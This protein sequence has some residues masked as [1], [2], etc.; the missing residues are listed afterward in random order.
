MYP[1]QE[2]YP[3][4]QPSGAE[5][6]PPQGP[7]G[8]PSEGVPYPYGQQGPYTPPPGAGPYS[9]GQ[10]GPYAP[11][12]PEA[13]PYSY[14]AQGPYMPYAGKVS[15]TR[16]NNAMI[17]GF[18]SFVLG[19]ITFAT[20]IGYAGLITG[21]FAIIYGFVGLNRAKRLPNNAGRRQAITGIIL[22]C[23]AWFIVILSL[24]ARSAF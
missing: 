18:I 23:V 10:Q 9:Y 8:T 7:Y 3:S 12:Q 6:Y 5:P 13:G 1:S 19:A 17:Y 20:N 24:M 2:P 22:G 21:T 15:N 4:P 14:G 11:P 16:A